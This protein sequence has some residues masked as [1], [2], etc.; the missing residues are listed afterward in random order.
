LTQYQNVAQTNGQIALSYRCVVHIIALL[1]LFVNLIC[2]IVLNVLACQS[3]S[4]SLLNTHGNV[5]YLIF[6]TSQALMWPGFVISLASYMI[7]R[8]FADGLVFSGVFSC[9]TTA[10]FSFDFCILFCMMGFRAVLSFLVLVVCRDSYCSSIVFF[11]CV[12]ILC[13][14]CF[15][16]VCCCLMSHA[17]K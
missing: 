14:F 2:Y 10:L 11:L 12:C 6:F 1:H 16:S 5:Q 4:C 15:L 9:L 8:W 3:I 13:V 7:C 17:D